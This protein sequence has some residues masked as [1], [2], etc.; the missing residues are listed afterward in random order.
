MRKFCIMLLFATLSFTSV[1]AQRFTDELDRGI[2]AVNLDGQV[3]VSWRILPEEYYG[4]TYNLYKNGSLMQDNLSVS[5]WT[6]SGNTSDQF[7]VAA[8]VNGVEGEKSAPAKVWNRF[9]DQAG[10]LTF[11]LSP[12]VDR[13]NRDV[14]HH[15]WSN[16]AISPTSTVMDSWSS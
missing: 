3:F 2:V 1:H 6:G 9:D 16:D 5:N 14:T 8:V 15:Y 11:T 13:N 4:T 7:T 12:I 10:L